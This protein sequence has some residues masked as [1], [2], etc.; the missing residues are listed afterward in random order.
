MRLQLQP[1]YLLHRRPYR[2]NSELVELLTAEHGRLGAIARGL[3]RKRSGGALGAV[4]QPF[5]P[6]LASL[7]GRGDLLTLTGV[8]TGG[9]L[10]VLTGD[11]MLCGFY[12][13]EILLRTLERFDSHPQIFVA[14]GRALEDL[15]RAATARQQALALRSCEFALLEDLGYAIDFRFTHDSGD[16]VCAGE[17]Y[18][19]VAGDGLVRDVSVDSGDGER[20]FRGED[21]LAI[22]EGQLERADTA[23]LK[24]ISR[25]LLSSHLGSEPL[26]SQ[27]V[28]RS[29][30]A[31]EREA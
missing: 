26:R 9:E 31:A 14:Y 22:A 4:L 12:L 3:G 19:V 24:R 30:R 18:R 8:E 20:S 1:A 29:L 10:E 5:R 13:N 16:A 21:L 27:E 15:G 7:S 6:L 23:A 28:F 25:L 11:A 17:R 2:D